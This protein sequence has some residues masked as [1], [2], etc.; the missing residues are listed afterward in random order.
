[1]YPS[2]GSDATVVV[3]VLG[4][5]GV[6]GTAGAFDGPASSENLALEGVD[7]LTCIKVSSSEFECDIV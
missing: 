5:T 6:A 7:C 4:V 3:S 1:M 2:R